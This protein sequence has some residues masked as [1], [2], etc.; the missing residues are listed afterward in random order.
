[1]YVGVSIGRLV[2][3]ES[4]EIILSPDFNW[5]HA[6]INNPILLPEGAAPVAIGDENGPLV[7]GIK[8]S[9]AGSGAEILAE[10]VVEKKVVNRFFSK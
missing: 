9:M 2:K 4:G 5:E 3:R 7:G 8:G 10:T 1:L 6:E